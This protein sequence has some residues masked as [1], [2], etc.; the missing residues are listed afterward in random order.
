LFL[1]FFSH[2]EIKFGYWINLDKKSQSNNTRN[3]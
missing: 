2:K 1:N 3:D